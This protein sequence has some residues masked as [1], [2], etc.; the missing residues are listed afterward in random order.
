MGRRKSSEDEPLMYPSQTVTLGFLRGK[1]V[2]ARIGDSKTKSELK[3]ISFTFSMVESGD[4][5]VKA[6]HRES[7]RD[8]GHVIMA[9]DIT[10]DQL[11][12]MKRARKTAKIPY[13]NGFIV[14][15][16]FYLVQLLS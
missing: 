16:C 13:H 8:D 11:D 7:A 10:N 9:F 3:S 1:K 4:W 15:N 2:I 12:D 6:L 14:F 5:H